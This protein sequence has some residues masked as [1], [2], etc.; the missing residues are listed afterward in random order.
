MKHKLAT[1]YKFGGFLPQAMRDAFVFGLRDQKLRQ[2][3][4]G[5]EDLSYDKARDL[6]M[7]SEAAAKKSKEMQ[8]G[9]STPQPTV[10][11]VQKQ[12][13]TSTPPQ[14]QQ[15]TECYR[16]GGKHKAAECKFKEAVCHF[17]KK[18]GHLAR[19]CRSKLK[20]KNAKTGSAHCLTRDQDSADDDI[21]EIYHVHQKR[22]STPPY[23][24]KVTLNGTPLQMEIDTCP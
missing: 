3:L 15:R 17:C 8:S 4:L 9:S 19:V 11:Q 16:C 20:Q 14:G 5:I 7:A 2:Q 18:R 21:E 6:A 1:H 10:Q 24:I 12:K 22:T 13:A 23:T